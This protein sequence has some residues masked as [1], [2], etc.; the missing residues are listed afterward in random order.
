MLHCVPVAAAFVV[1]HAAVPV[2]GEPYIVPSV[3]EVL[4][5]LAPSPH[6]GQ[7]QCLPLVLVLVL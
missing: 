2:V 1:E 7:S 5:E 6:L 4:F 3:Q